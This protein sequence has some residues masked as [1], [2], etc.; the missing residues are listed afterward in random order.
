MIRGEDKKAMYRQDYLRRTV[1]D[2]AF[3]PL[4][5]DPK[6]ATASDATAAFKRLARRFHPD[7][8][9]GDELFCSKFFSKF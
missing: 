9:K 4:K 6:I 8:N 7:K 3:R 2:E 5:L 1:R